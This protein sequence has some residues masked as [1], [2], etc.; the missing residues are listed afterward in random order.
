MAYNWNNSEWRKGWYQRKA[1]EKKWRLLW[2]LSGFV[3]REVAMI[4]T[5]MLTQTNG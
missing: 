1:Y 4:V 2:I 5:K 3:F